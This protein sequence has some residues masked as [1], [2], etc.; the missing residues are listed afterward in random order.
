MTDEKW[1]LTYFRVLSRDN[2]KTHSIMSPEFA[3]GV[4][5][6]LSTMEIC[7]MMCL[8]PSFPL[9][10][11]FYALFFYSPPK[12]T[13]NRH[14]PL[15]FDQNYTS[16]FNNNI[17]IPRSMGTGT[18][19]EETFLQKLEP[20]RRR[21]ERWRCP[22]KAE[23]KSEKS[24]GFSPL[25]IFQSSVRNYHWQ[26]LPKCSLQRSLGSEVFC[27]SEQSRGST[28]NASHSKQVGAA[29]KVLNYP[30]DHWLHGTKL[31]KI[32]ELLFSE[33]HTETTPHLNCS[34]QTTAYSR[35]ATAGPFAGDGQLPP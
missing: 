4:E 13:H 7:L 14:L 33:H 31:I 6:L 17:S 26:K 9:L 24:S 1:S 15:A 28:R 22:P 19:E 11:C 2:A 27:I 23:G 18:T 12:P 30:S 34:H 21:N 16:M 35:D 5:P 20:W 8:L 25:P 10:P 3:S 32:S 29:M